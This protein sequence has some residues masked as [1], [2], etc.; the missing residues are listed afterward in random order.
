MRFGGVQSGVCRGR[1]G[2]SRHGGTESGY[3]GTETVSV[4][5]DGV[6]GDT[7][8]VVDEHPSGVRLVR[9]NVLVRCIAGRAR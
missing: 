5:C 8:L 3:D 1:C 2:V 7:H 4:W 6:Q 9:A